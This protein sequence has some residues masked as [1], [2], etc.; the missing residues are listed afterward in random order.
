MILKVCGVTRVQDASAAAQ[1][2]ATA[3]GLN[4]WSQSPRCLATDSALE[5]VLALPPSVTPVG[6]FVNASVE[7]IRDIVARVG[8]G[9][10][11]LHGEEPPEYAELMGIPIWRSVT[12]ESAT[13]AFDSWPQS[14]TFLLDAQDASRRGGTGRPVER[15]GAAALAKKKPVVLAGGLTPD[16]V[17][18]TIREVRPAGVDVSSGVEVAPGVKSADMITR[19]LMNAREAFEA[20]DAR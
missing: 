18:Q 8:L 14:T 9:A 20:A 7:G 5:I 11:Q 17:A 13:D 16:N 2:G 6:V 1:A 12:L 4:F 15:E 19:F 3:V 10:V